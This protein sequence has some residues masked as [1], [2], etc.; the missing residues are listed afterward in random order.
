MMNIKRNLALYLLLVVVF[1]CSISLPIDL[2]AQENIRQKVEEA[3]NSP[4]GDTAERL[5]E[6]G[7]PAVP[8]LVEI[9]KGNEFPGYKFP[10]TIITALGMIGDKKAVP[11]FLEMLENP[12]YSVSMSIIVVAL[13][14]IGDP[15]S[16]PA[17]LSYFEEEQRQNSLYQLEIAPA[18]LKVGADASRQKVKEMVSYVR[19]LYE[20]AMWTF[21][22]EAWKEVANELRESPFDNEEIVYAL[23]AGLIID[24]KDV[25]L[26]TRAIKYRQLVDETGPRFGDGFKVLAETGTPGTI[27]T[28]FK[29][30]E[31]SEEMWP[32][33]PSEITE[34]ERR[35]ICQ[36][37]PLVRVAAV[38]TLLSVDGVD[39]ERVASAFEDISVEGLLEIPLTV[40]LQ[41]DKWNY[42]WKKVKGKDD[43]DNDDGEG[44][45]KISCYLGNIPGGYS[46]RDILPETILLNGKLSPSQ[47]G[48]K[49]KI[50]AR[51]KER[52][53]GFIGE[54]LEVKFNKFDAIKSI[55]SLWPGKECNII[56]TGRLSDDKPFRGSYWIKI[57]KKEKREKK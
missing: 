4:W 19:D 34:E 25:E 26:L 6:I 41:P 1:I 44:K 40:K 47:E 48:K 22:E 29:F 17:I 18:L 50:H 20:R 16:E 9:L 28:I 27:E 42:Q 37:P 23:L 45:G 31:N 43:E 51:I 54:V 53:K 12:E 2:F 13:G 35:E 15:S 8:L 55:A 36:V 24:L 30:A 3:L 46:V 14:M 56:I 33:A 39:L 11:L 7:K 57:S 49:G 10:A 32:S 52:H 21:D 38:E 5:A